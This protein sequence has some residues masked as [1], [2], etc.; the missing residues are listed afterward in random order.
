MTRGRILTVLLALLALTAVPGAFALAATGSEARPGAGVSEQGV[1]AQGHPRL[2]ISQA[3]VDRI[4]ASGPLPPAFEQALQRARRSVDPY[5][6]ALPDVPTPVDPGGG[7]THEQ[8][9]RNATIIQNAGILYLLTGEQAYAQLGR[10]LLNAYARLYPGLSEHPEKKNQAAGK[11]FWQSL[12]E[13]VWLVTSIQGYDA[14]YRSL[15]SE[16]RSFIE[17]NLFRPMVTFLSDEAP[18]TF[19]KIHNHGT[20]AVA[21]VG[22]T[23]Y[24]LGDQEYIEK[25]L[26]GLEKN[27]KAG[28]MKQ[29]DLLFSPDGYYSEGPYYQRYAL[30]PFLL[31]A[32][33][34]ER[35]DPARKIFSYRDGILLNAV[36]TTIHLSYGGYFF[37]I[38][39]ALKDKG[40]DTVEL[41][42]G[43]AIAYGMTSDPG[44]VSIAEA[45]QRIVLT[46]DGFRLAEAM[47]QG[48]GQPFAFASRQFS[49]GP[50]GQMG[51][52]ALLRN[53]I[54]DNEQA[55]VFKATGQGMGHGHFDRLGWLF[56]DNGNEIITDYGA[57]RFL[58]VE[59]KNGGR[60]LPENTSWAKQTVAHNTL[61]VDR[62]S[63]FD[64]DWKASEKVGTTPLLFAAT[65]AIKIT[66]ARMQGAYP[67]VAF[68]RVMAL[69]DTGI[70]PHPIVLDVLKADSQQ[71]HM[72]DLPLHYKGHITA[73]SQ[74]LEVATKTLSTLGGDHGYQHLWYRAKADVASGQL[75]QLTWLNG[76]RFYTYSTLADAAMHAVLTETGATDP[77]F[78]L[79][80]EPGLILR[81]R[82]VANQTFVSVLEPH[83]E[84]DGSREFTTASASQL[85]GLKRFS[86]NGLDLIRISSIDGAQIHLALSYNTDAKAEHS[87]QVDGKTWDW[88]GYYA[89][90]E[91]KAP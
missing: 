33:S 69:L 88:S 66:A 6:Q 67:G 65:E 36:Y 15:N 5:L 44:L 26:F 34:I 79:R 46:G 54:G 29:L 37:P 10:D 51:A 61:V 86:Q 53:Q 48:I 83:G 90:F 58:N 49:D 14:I 52:L 78:N 38:N 68:S 4:I 31:F 73:V 21:A 76:D 60:Y 74:P 12:N 28:F 16:E 39:D 81:A 17:Q 11:L 22:M 9:K 30:M 41:C 56:Y 82:D 3:E 72:Y 18:Q 8:H 24:V 63:Q 7:Y 19:D 20:W 35:N 91:D 1:M 50:D 57:A 77:Q 89:L 32:Q 87:I 62:K 27:G 40:L 80:W 45:Q 64:G 55:L 47:Q 13:A 2:L 71:P 25:A 59:E 43:V 85:R 84:Y 42:Y 70:F 75:F 23:G